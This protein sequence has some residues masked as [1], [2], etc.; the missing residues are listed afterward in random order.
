MSIVLWPVIWLPPLRVRFSIEWLLF[1]PSP[2]KSKTMT[3]PNG[4]H[5]AVFQVNFSPHWTKAGMYHLQLVLIFLIEL[6]QLYQTF[7]HHSTQIHVDLNHLNH[8]WKL[9]IAQC[10]KQGNWM[11]VTCYTCSLSYCSYCSFLIF[12]FFLIFLTW[13]QISWEITT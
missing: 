12:L 4:P 6:R 7:E 3:F 10:L 8:L 1:A 9:T 13:N 11:L 2:K 5:V